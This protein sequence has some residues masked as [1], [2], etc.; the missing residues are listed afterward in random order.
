MVLSYSNLCIAKHPA[1]SLTD[2]TITLLAAVGSFESIDL[3][4]KKTKIIRPHSYFFGVGY[5]SPDVVLS[6]IKLNVEFLKH[7]HK[8]QSFELILY[9]S[10][11]SRKFF[12]G[13]L[14][15]SWG[16][17]DGISTMLG[18]HPKFEEYRNVKTRRLLNFLVIEQNMFIKGNSQYKVTLR[19]HHRCHCFKTIAPKGAGS[20]FFGL[21][22]KYSF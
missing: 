8:Q 2:H 9:P 4:L 21:G 18:P 1:K 12:I 15:L 13:N 11:E 7:F 20:N 17:G 19:W 14:G 3:I 5:R 16:I 10:I 22:L 6:C